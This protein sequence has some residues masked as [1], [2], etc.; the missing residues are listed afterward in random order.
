MTTTTWNPDIMNT[1]ASGLR[2]IGWTDLNGSGDAM[3]VNFH[4]S[5][6]YAY[7]GHMGDT[8]IGTS[9][10]DIS[11]PRNPFV[12][13]QLT[14]PDGVRS[15]KVAVVDDVLV[16][17]YEGY[18]FQPVDPE[19]PTGFK[20][21][22]L[23]D[24]ANPRELS[25]YH[26]PGKGVHRMKFTEMPYCYVSGSDTGFHE[27]RQTF[28]IMDLSDP[29]NPTEVSRWWFP[30][31]NTG[32][33]ETPSWHPDRWVWNHHAH[34]VG[35]RAYCAWWDAGV[36]ILDISDKTRPTLVSHLTFDD[37]SSPPRVA[38]SVHTVLAV[39]EKN[40]L[41]VSEEEL[42]DGVASYKKYVRVIDISDEQRPRQIS[43]LPEPQGD[44]AH[45]GGR[46]GPHNLHE[47]RPGTYQ[48]PDE[49]FVTYFNAGV[50]VYDI[51]DPF[52][53]REI[54]YHVPPAP[55]GDRPIHMND[56]IVDANG[57]IYATDRHGGGLYIMERTDA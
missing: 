33:G 10:V 31:M 11:D 19:L 20:I 13:N 17:N 4:R 48:N 38:G 18:P 37:L 24:P 32:A 6:K 50:R 52:S 28:M 27:D 57:L 39:P 53:P 9:V 16:V 41:I 25:Y 51:S 15:H 34:I 49:V 7:V 36:I 44:F 46:F 47:G 54:A 40:L 1:E 42:E 30:G 43:I 21:F 55:D 2:V 45:R 12:V 5:G 22:S 8:E 23:E 14:K 56:L 26:M 35:D 29:M 3:H